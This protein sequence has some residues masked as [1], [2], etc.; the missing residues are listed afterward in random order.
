[1]E[2][3]NSIAP[4]CNELKHKYDD[5]FNVWFTE[6]FLKGE[7]G[8]DVCAPMLKVYQDCVQKALVDRKINLKDINTDVLNTPDDK[9]QSHP[10]GKSKN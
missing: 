1:M 3:M 2:R 6:K 8:D 4:E 7:S 10:L 5:C 9:S